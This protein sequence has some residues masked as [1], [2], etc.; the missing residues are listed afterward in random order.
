M[1]CLSDQGLSYERSLVTIKF[2]CQLDNDI[3]LVS[4]H[5]SETRSALQGDQRGR[6][7]RISS[8]YDVA[9]ADVS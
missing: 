6:T 5:G 2:A 4:L 3:K 7:W 8:V 1:T 9:A